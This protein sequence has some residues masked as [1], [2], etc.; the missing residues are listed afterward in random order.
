MQMFLIISALWIWLATIVC[1]ST[2]LVLIELAR[3][4]TEA[5]TLTAIANPGFHLAQLTATPCTHLV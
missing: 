1:G 3:T 2:A 4:T 5:C